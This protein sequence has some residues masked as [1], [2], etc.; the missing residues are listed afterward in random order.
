MPGG[1]LSPCEPDG[2]IM[3]AMRQ[4]SEQYPGRSRLDKSLGLFTDVRA[5][6]ALGA[7]L[8]AADIFCLLASYYL[9]KT[10][11]ES[12]ILAESSAEVKSYAAGA[13]AL[14]LLA[15][16]PLYGMVAS[17]VNRSRLINGVLLFF[18]SHL[19]IFHVLASHGLHIGIAFFLWVGVFNLMIVAQFWSFAN[20]VYT[21][22]RG[23]RLFP[24]V[25]V[26]GSL[27]AWFGA[28]A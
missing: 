21:F 15:A 26:G 6:E 25:G 24:L 3:A 2:D 18:T 16:V 4:T 14:I 12:L 1:L 10:A 20:D 19:A 23:Q 22:E 17:R 11:R 27:G 13:Q 28:R 5:G 7:L 9:L 8:L